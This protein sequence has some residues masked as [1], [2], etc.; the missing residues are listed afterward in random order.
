MDVVWN[1]GYAETAAVVAI[2]GF[3]MVTFKELI[4]FVSVVRG[5]VT[6]SELANV[7]LGA[8]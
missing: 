6:S 3:D 4:V 8:V 7:M 5:S 2:D 1:V